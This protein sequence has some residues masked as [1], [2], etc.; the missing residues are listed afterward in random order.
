MLTFYGGKGLYRYD[1]IKYREM[2][3]LSWI[4][5]VVHKSHHKNP[6][7]KE[8]EGVNMHRGEDSVTTEAEIQGMQP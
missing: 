8:T 1:S 5:R 6:Y 3:T 4:I 7:I 2:E